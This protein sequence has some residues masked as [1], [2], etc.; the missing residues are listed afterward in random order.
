KAEIIVGDYSYVRHYTPS[1]LKNKVVITDSIDDEGIGLLKKRGVRTIITTVPELFK[2]HV[3]T[4]VLHAICTAYLEKKPQERTENDY[5][6]MIDRSGLQPRI[7]YPQGAPKEKHKF[8]FVIHPL[9]R[10]YLFKHPYLRWMEGAPKPAQELVE[11]TFAYA[12][13]FI[14]SH[15]TG[16]KSPQGVEAEG[17]L[18]ALGATPE[19]MMSRDPEFTYKRLVEAS[20]MAE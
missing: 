11:K 16:I 15:V 20:Q 10:R 9:S 19:E 3:D 5:L 1:Q 14:Y 4:N 6:D 2:Q 18:I 13:P 17:W 7:I 12:P 8:A